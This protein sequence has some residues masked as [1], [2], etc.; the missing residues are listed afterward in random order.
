[1]QRR[2]LVLRILALLTAG[3]WVVGCT[4]SGVTEQSVGPT[5]SGTPSPQSTSASLPPSGLD[6]SN[7]P[8]S[9]RP[10]TTSSPAADAEAADRTAAE[11]QWIK[12]WDVYLAMAA[13]PAAERDALASTVTID[14][15][16]S[17][18][19]TD[20]QEFDKQGLQ[21]YGQIG[22]RISWP[23]AINGADT[24]LIDDCQDRSNSGSLEAS[25][26][27]KVTVGVAGLHYQGQLVR[28]DDG[29]W[30]VSQS[31]FLKDEPC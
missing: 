28:G 30:R 25:T 13:T 20:A 26:G 9:T 31:Y 24:A 2:R 23:Q 21:T 18:M 19:L 16:K 15:A 12:S 29:I 8:S 11:A 10:A 14:P 7:A 22:H 27:N 17:K 4:G 6:A 5:G 1:M 3:L